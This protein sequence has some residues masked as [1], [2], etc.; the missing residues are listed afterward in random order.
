MQR[1]VI[2]GLLGAAIV[3]AHNTSSMQAPTINLIPETIKAT[4][5]TNLLSQPVTIVLSHQLPQETA[6]QLLGIA[7]GF[8]GAYNLCATLNS[9]RGGTCQ[10]D[11]SRCFW[12]SALSTLIF[13]AG[14]GMI[15]KSKQLVSYFAT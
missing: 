3:H 2:I 13:L 10:N 14:A 7:I 8:G 15:V 6:I 11:N 9:W 5:E 12:S 4:L 1:I